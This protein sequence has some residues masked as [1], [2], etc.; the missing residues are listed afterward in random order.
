MPRD[1]PDYIESV[2]KAFQVI[3]AF[4]ATNPTLTISEAAA[5]TGL[6]RPTVRRLLLTLCRLGF[7]SQPDGKKFAL[8]PQMMRLGYAYLSST[9]V[10]DHALPYL[11]D[12]ADSVRESVS[13]AVFDS[14]DIVYVARVPAARSMTITLT[15]GARL[16]AYPTSLGRALL[17]GLTTTELDTYLDRTELVRLTSTT[18]TDPDA[19]RSELARVRD[20]GYA[21]IDGEREEGVR[22]AAVP[23]KDRQGRTIMA[24]NVSANSARMSVETLRDDVVPQLLR[25]AETI[26]ANGRF[27]EHG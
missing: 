4:S 7:A 12:L 22:S 24:L 27:V 9:P 19:L 21:I 2:S 16:P 17:A 23:I 5:L 3:E 11:R 20:Q 26:S 1:D 13:L 14:P 8:T 10:W 25:T 6:T 15:V 18:I